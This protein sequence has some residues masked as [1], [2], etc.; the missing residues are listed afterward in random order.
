MTISNTTATSEFNSRHREASLFEEIL[1]PSLSSSR[2]ICSDAPG[3]DSVEKW[4]EIRSFRHMISAKACL[5][6]TLTA[7]SEIARSGILNLLQLREN[8]KQIDLVFASAVNVSCTI[9]RTGCIRSSK[10]AE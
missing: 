8:K 3:D 10:S 5:T 7:L 9:C 2:I 1:R 4:P 6:S